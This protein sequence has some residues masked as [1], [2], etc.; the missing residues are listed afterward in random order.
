MLFS[1]P[2][3]GIAQKETGGATFLKIYCSKEGIHL[4]NMEVV[5]VHLR[6]ARLL[7]HLGHQAPPHLCVPQHPLLCASLS[8]KCVF[9]HQFSELG[10]WATCWVLSQESLFLICPSSSH[11]F[12]SA[13][14]LCCCSE[15]PR[16]GCCCGCF[17]EFELVEA[18]NSSW[19]TENTPRR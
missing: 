8:T 5:L 3:K 11:F 1:P 4:L 18:E 7:A 6:G 13:P 14:T 9:K 17:P 12:A 15:L 16:P 2:G 19:S 10:Y